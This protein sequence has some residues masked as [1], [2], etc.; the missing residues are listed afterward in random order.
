MTRV[1]IFAAS[2]AATV[3]AIG[4]LDWWVDPFADRYD[5]AV[6]TAALERPDPCLVSHTVIG[7]RTW[8]EFKV[9]LARRRGHRT[10]V[11]GTSR[12]WK[13]AAHRGEEG[14][15]NLSLPGMGLAAVQPLFERI[16]GLGDEPTTVYL[17]AEV[18]WFSARHRGPKMFAHS[19]RDDV[20]YL[21]S[22][23]TLSA[24]LDV[25][26]RAP[27]AIRHPQKLRPWAIVDTPRGCLVDRE[28]SVLRGA[29]NAWGPDGTWYWQWEITGQQ[30]PA[31]IPFVVKNRLD[32][33]GRRLDDDKVRALEGALEL[34]EDAGWKV[35]GFSPPFSSSSI[36]RLAN[37]PET[38]GLLADFRARMPAIFERH[39]FAFVDLTD[40]ATIPCPQDA[41]TWED[42]AHVDEAC[43]RRVRARLDAAARRAS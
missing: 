28:A 5:G 8:P 26:R 1:A 32:F 17:G 43:A 9:D 33:V 18:L 3:A 21:L 6:L 37:D 41:F 4:A 29:A 12:V 13:L 20:R 11:A 31:G 24:T 42:G 16:R 36:E 10:V 23:E 39:G 19:V 7:E 34:A 25:L 15:A 27:G 35:V 40:V 30:I 2:V 38:G 14:F 22:A